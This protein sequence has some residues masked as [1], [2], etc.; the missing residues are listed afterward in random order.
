[1]TERPTYGDPQISKEED[2][3]K[4]SHPRQAS[5]KQANNSRAANNRDRG[6][7]GAAIATRVLGIAKRSGVLLVAMPWAKV[8][9]PS[10]Q[11]G[12]LH[13]LLEQA[14]IEC[15]PIFAYLRFMEHCA[16]A[17][18]RALSVDDYNE[19]AVE[20]FIGDWIFAVPPFRKEPA[21]VSGYVDYLRRTGAP[22]TAIVKAPQFRR[23]VATF[24]KKLTTEI[25]AA[26]PRVVGFTTTFGQTVPSLVL[27]K[28]LRA[29]DPSIRIVFGGANCQGEMGAALLRLF[30]WIDVVVRGEAE[31]VIKSL[32][33][34]L[35][36]GMP[37][38]PRP[39]LCYREGAKV[40]I[41]EFDSEALPDMDQVPIPNYDG[42]FAELKRL[43]IAAELHPNISIPIE[44][45]RGCWWGQKNH[46]TFCGLNGRSMAFRSQGAKR[47]VETIHYLAGRH[48]HLSFHAVDNIIDM[49]YFDQFLPLLRASEFDIE[50][51]YETKA[52]LRVGHLKLMRAAGVTEIQP[53][54]ESL[55]TSILKR[56]RKG[57][58]ALQNIRL[59]RHCAALGIRVQWN[60]IYGFPGEEPI[61]Y[62]RMARL[63]PSLSHLEPPHLSRLSLQRFSPYFE[64]PSAFG[65]VKGPPLEHYGWI[66]PIPN[67]EL[68]H[69]AYSFDY[70][71]TD[72]RKP[73]TYVAPLREEVGRWAASYS[74]DH[75]PALRSARGPGFLI[76]KDRRAGLE[77][78]DYRLGG[79]EARIYELC[80]DGATTEGI[81]C[82]LRASGD[83]IASS[84][85]QDFLDLLVIARL[86]YTEDTLYLSL[87][88]PS[89]KVVARWAIA[90]ASDEAATSTGRRRLSMRVI[91]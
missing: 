50:L 20:Y 17:S 34:E 10:I 66:Y 90:E 72:G 22:E 6:A 71:Y 35:I 63:I 46:C 58:S 29:R 36:A 67:G 77:R 64:N 88:V 54:I 44:T 11:L 83:T 8:E 15:T 91:G 43:E 57:V 9:H 52:N 14:G 70:S 30:P 26:R 28:M 12:I 18:S 4:K 85:I 49:R 86:V 16:R 65:L 5:A 2:E 74:R 37:I 40:H 69:I 13:A 61:E 38:T 78:A 80:E 79:R 7:A 39:G 55:S 76:I 41:V 68:D 47:A 59:L 19:I 1:M 48:Q 75:A 45:A 25:V 73:E 32:M 87:A 33:S 53:G 31:L 56:M 27:A 62:E 42:Y 24:L 81:A 60:I 89:P 23:H 84:E 21:N 3:D 51:F 82:A